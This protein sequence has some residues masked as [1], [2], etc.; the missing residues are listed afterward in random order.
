M[1]H[2]AK[3][4]VQLCCLTALWS[5]FAP[6]PVQA[7]GDLLVAP[8]RVVINGGGNAEVVLSNIGDKPATYRIS[9]ELRRMDENGDF[10]EVEE[11]AA[12]ETEKA[13]L[14]M[15]RYAPRRVTLMPGQ[16]QAVR[17]SIRPPEDLPDGEYRVHMGFRAVPGSAT[18]DLSQ[19][20]DGA[21]NGVSIKLT[22]IFGI[23]I[24][25][26]L[27]KGIR[28]GQSDFD[29]YLF[30]D[31]VPYGTYRL[32]LS[33]EAAAKMGVGPDLGGLFRINHERASLRMGQLRTR[34]QSALPSL[35]RAD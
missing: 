2:I 18:A 22:P 9:I 5:L 12:N 24:P 33:A 30:F 32:R 1:I 23:T 34:P 26:F 6:A 27:R 13:T 35:A 11:A 17:L 7:Q 3:W 14:G 25:V 31:S 10:Q 19:E 16:P 21:S 29:G 15:V 4:Y 20:R 28:R 8:T